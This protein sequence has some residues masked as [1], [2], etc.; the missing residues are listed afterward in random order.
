VVVDEY[1]WGPD[2]EIPVAELSDEGTRRRARRGRGPKS[3]RWS[4]LALAAALFAGGATVA[5][6]VVNDADN[7][8]R[9]RVATTPRRNATTIDNGQARVNVLA[10]L[11]ATVA[12]GSYRIHSTM[13]EIAPDGTQPRPPIVADGIVNVDPPVTI[14]TSNVSGI[15][16]ITARIDGNN[17]WEQGGADFGM[18]ADATASPGAPLSQFAG[19]VAGSLGKR[20]GAVAMQSM[21]S[22]NGYLH[23]AE[24]A[25]DNASWLG[26]TVFAGVPVHMYEV[27]VDAAKLLE[28]PGLTPEQTKAGVAAM[29]EMR[30]QGYRTTT[31]RL[32][33][34][35][36]GFVRRT[37]TSVRFADGGSVDADVNF[38]DFGCS[39]VVML[40]NG[41]WIGS[42][43]AG[44][45][46]S[47]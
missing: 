21:A 39:A 37:Q 25:V 22:P 44:C 15:G 26:D 24:E 41:P 30:A 32:S 16:P 4:A 42:H 46:A 5:A 33:I 2:D 8:A 13:T 23:V 3:R 43:P 36:G 9:R 19:L 12:A 1:G 47:P 40:P 14:A 17:V 11:R 29:T 31:V 34:D 6:W 18:T 28:R 45:S 27:E 10:A 20:A 7:G 38:S 35:A